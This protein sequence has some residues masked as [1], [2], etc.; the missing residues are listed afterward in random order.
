MFNSLINFIVVVLLS[1]VTGLTVAV[2][3]VC[4]SL[5]L[6]IGCIIILC[7]AYAI[8]VRANSTSSTNH[9]GAIHRG[10]SNK[11]NNDLT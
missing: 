9:I 3:Y 1:S 10:V 8:R 4:A 7:V 6:I 5:A 11:V 2:V